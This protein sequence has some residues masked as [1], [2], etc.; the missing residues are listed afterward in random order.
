MGRHGHSQE[1]G[2]GVT[3]PLL[4]ESQAQ[5]RRPLDLRG[6]AG[7]QNHG[8]CPNGEHARKNYSPGKWE[9]PREYSPSL[10]SSKRQPPPPPA[11]GQTD[12]A[13]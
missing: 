8:S 7:R 9:G 3:S 5:M 13:R 1:E 11:G 12:E 6:A 10:S 2:Q 4:S